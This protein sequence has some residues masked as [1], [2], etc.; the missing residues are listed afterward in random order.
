MRS[1][2]IVFAIVSTPTGPPSKRYKSVFRYKIS[3]SSR[4]IGSI[5]KA[6][7]EFEASFLEREQ[8]E[9]ANNI[10]K[11]L[12][13]KDIAELLLD[14]GLTDNDKDKVQEFSLELRDI[15]INGKVKTPSIQEIPTEQD[16][17]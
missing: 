7:S 13:K 12:F 14:M 6:L 16:N 8:L 2:P 9:M 3:T 11:E 5:F 10:Y 4:P 1:S 17:I 15:L